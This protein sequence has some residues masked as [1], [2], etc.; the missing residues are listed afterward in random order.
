MEQCIILG[1][2]DQLVQTHDVSSLF[3]FSRN[4]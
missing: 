3:E 4:T 1:L 2:E